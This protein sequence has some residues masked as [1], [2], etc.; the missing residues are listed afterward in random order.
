MAAYKFAENIVTGK[1]VPLFETGPD[2]QLMRDFTYVEDIVSGVLSALDRVPERCGEAFNLGYGQPLV[3]E[4]MLDY[5]QQELN[6]TAIIV[7]HLTH[8]ATIF[9]M[10]MCRIDSHFL[11]VT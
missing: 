6:M 3:V 8:N 2:E 10:P 9:C 5:L 7:S 4:E 1:P 11:Q